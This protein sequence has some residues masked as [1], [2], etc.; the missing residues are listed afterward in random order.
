MVVNDMKLLDWMWLI[1]LLL[2]LFLPATATYNYGLTVYMFFLLGYSIG[3]NR[4][5]RDKEKQ[6]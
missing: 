3:L 2:I 4:G 1:A 6:E 5:K